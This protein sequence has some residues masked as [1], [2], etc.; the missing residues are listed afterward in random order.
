[1]E[2]IEETA[3]FVVNNIWKYLAWF[4]KGAE[5]GNRKCENIK[6]QCQ[7]FSSVRTQTRGLA[8][9]PHSEEQEEKGEGQVKSLQW[10][11]VQRSIDCL[12]LKGNANSIRAWEIQLFSIG[13]VWY[14]ENI[15]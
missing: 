1:M 14:L 11:K 13:D 10:H 9:L 3:E 12:M 6:E 5:S 8:Q 15:R 2:I 4:G 7:H